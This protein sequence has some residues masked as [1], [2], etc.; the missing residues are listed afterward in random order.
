MKSVLITGASR[1][2]GQAIALHLEHRKSEL[3]LEI[4][5]VARKRVDLGEG[6]KFIEADISQASEVK[7]VFE[8][9][10]GPGFS[11]LFGLICCAG[12]YGPI[13]PFE[14]IDPLLLEEV[15]RTNFLGSAY[16]AQ[17]AIPLMKANGSGRI[18]FFSGGGEASMPRFAPYVST[19]G[20]IWRLTET[21]GAELSPFGIMVN[22]IAPGPVNTQFLE[23]ALQAGP[24]ATGAEMYKKLLTQKQSGGDSPLNAANLAQYLLSEKS[25]GLSGKT[26]SAK[27]DPLA[28]FKNYSQSELEKLSA[29]K[30]Y[31]FKR[32]V[33]S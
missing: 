28:T 22:A 5:G 23:D 9:L 31:T 33:R 24:D 3:G 26:L 15:F 2:I 10:Q 14:S 8:L 16:C 18:V 19:K 7:R 4:I 20:A 11:P 12:I 30:I 6:I 21:L 25:N 27:W 29:S 13:G 1:G 17:A 32:E